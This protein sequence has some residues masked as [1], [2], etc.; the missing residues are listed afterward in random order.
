METVLYAPIFA[1]RRVA[2][3]SQF[4]LRYM[5][6]ASLIAWRA[7]CRDTYLVATKELRH[8]LHT[9]LARFV[10]DPVAFLRYLTRWGAIIVGQ[11]ALSHILYDP[12][13]FSRTLELATSNLVFE[14]FVHGL[15][16]RLHSGPHAVGVNIVAKLAPPAW[17]SLRHITRIT[18]L[19][20]ASGP[21]MH[22]YESATPS[23]CDVVSGAWTTLLMNYV[24][25]S[26]FGCAY[27][28]LKLNYRGLLCDGRIGCLRWLDQATHDH[29]R[30]R[31]A[32]FIFHSLAWPGPSYS[33]SPYSSS[34]STSPPL[35]AP[36]GKTIH[37]CPFQGGYFGDPGSLVV[38]YDGFCV[39]L[40]L[41]RYTCAPP[42]G[43]MS[44][45]RIAM[46]AMCAG[47]CAVDES[48]LPAYV[49]CI[50]LQF[51]HD[52]PFVCGPEDPTAARTTPAGSPIFALTTSSSR[53]ARRMSI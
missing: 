50:I 27:P 9:M 45:W 25:E 23:A 44:A 20:L 39:N 36:C 47:Q 5:T 48:V 32:E 46:K 21:V 33:M 29:L 31:G 26:S 3:A 41:L 2:L 38:F 37:V 34:S 6:M 12:S 1:N 10:P 28:R 52:T 8:S 19:E 51:M 14:N 42:Y 15:D 16:H 7:T 30:A 4:A 35:A 53:V 24:S 13:I 40:P 17:L 22:V 11:A 49:T 43:S 18:E